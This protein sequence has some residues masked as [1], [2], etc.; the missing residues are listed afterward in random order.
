MD[1]E[2][3]IGVWGWDNAYIYMS[4]IDPNYSGSYTYLAYCCSNFSPN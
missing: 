3:L 2:S 4:D 1:E